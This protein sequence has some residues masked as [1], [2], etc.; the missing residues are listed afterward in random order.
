MDNIKL[1]N[2]LKSI[3]SEMV[4]LQE[5]C[6]HLETSYNVLT[7]QYMNGDILQPVGRQQNKILR[8]IDK[9]KKKYCKLEMQA[10]KIRQKLS[11]Q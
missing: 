4:Q 6:K 5:Y 8:E 2:K 3:Q 7:D 1:L 11:C 9:V 10:Y